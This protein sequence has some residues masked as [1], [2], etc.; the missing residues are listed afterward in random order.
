MTRLRRALGALGC[1]SV[2][3][4]GGP[5]VAQQGAGTHDG[6]VAGVATWIDEVPAD[7][8]TAPSATAVA[9]ILMDADSGQVLA[10]RDA[11]LRR[12]VASTIKL[13][14]VLTALDVLD[15]DAPV[16]VGD[17]VAIGGAGVGLAPGMTWT[18][19]DLVDAVLVRS[20]NDAARALA[21]AAGGDIAGFVA[22]MELKA[23]DLGL[24][25]ATIGDPTGLDDVNL[26]SAR[27]LA[28]IARAARENEVIRAAA[29]KP[30]VALP[31]QP[32]MENRNLL[33]G[34]YPG[35][36][37]LKTGYTDAAGWSLVATARAGDADLVAVVLGARVDEDRFSEAAGLLDHAQEALDRLVTGPLAVSVPGGALPV[38]D[39]PATV[40]AP[41]GA[42]VVGALEVRDG[43]ETWVLRIGD[44][45]VANAR[46]STPAVSGSTGL[47]ARLAAAV[48]RGMRQAHIVNAWPTPS[49]AVEGLG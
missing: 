28:V 9:Y 10:A 26:L 5:A 20:G 37:G 19:R 7:W 4:I 39:G 43:G 23:A 42:R 15:L 31:G 34:T 13:L 32:E 16:T 49:T 22:M 24:M 8:P 14:T 21:V 38:L 17:E 36:T 33:L 30:S 11:D 18:V 40:W 48:H 2:L 47:G 3:A 44:D 29:A 45:E 46:L 12:P 41:S 35:A 6:D 27:D 1:C 25:G